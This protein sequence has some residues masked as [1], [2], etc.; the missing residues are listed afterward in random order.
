MVDRET[1]IRMDEARAA[2][3]RRGVRVSAS[4]F[5]E[6][7]LKELLRRHGELADIMRRHKARPRRESGD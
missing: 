7:A 1:A 2:L 6:I 3:N 4:M 5:V